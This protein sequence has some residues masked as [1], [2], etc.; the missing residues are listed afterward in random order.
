MYVIY[1]LMTSTDRKAKAFGKSFFSQVNVALIKT[2][3]NKINK[4]AYIYTFTFLNIYCL[5]K[6]AG[7]CSHGFCKSL[8]TVVSRKT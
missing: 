2:K 1:R 5:E 6:I 7:F 3:Q 4:V 8:N